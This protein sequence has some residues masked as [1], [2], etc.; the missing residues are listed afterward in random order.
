MS[1]QV[2]SG[3]KRVTL[4]Q[5]KN[6]IFGVPLSKGDCNLSRQGEL[7]NDE[8]LEEFH[9]LAYANARGADER[10]DAVFFERLLDLARAALPDRPFGWDSVLTLTVNNKGRKFQKTYTYDPASGGGA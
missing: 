2:R 3:N 7:T 9:W 8:I 4:T 10:D 1:Q 5:A 6:V